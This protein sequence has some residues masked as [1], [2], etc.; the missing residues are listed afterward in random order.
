MSFAYLKMVRGEYFSYS[1]CESIIN[2]LETTKYETEFSPSNHKKED[3]RGT[4][5]QFR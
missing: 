2:V 4:V 1:K 3:Y 5:V